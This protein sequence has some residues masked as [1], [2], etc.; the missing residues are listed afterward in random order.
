M[1]QGMFLDSNKTRISISGNI[2]L[3]AG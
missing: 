2:I 1:T 3:D